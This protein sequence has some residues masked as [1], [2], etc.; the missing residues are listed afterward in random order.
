MKIVIVTIMVLFL[1]GCSGPMTV[2]SLC[3]NIVSYGVTGKTNSDIA[4]SVLLGQDCKLVRVLN[5]GEKV[6]RAK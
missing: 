5:E 3:S 6:C 2:V 4:V 1:T